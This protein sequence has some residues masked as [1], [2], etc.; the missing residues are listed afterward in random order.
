MQLSL[1][2]FKDLLADGI[3]YTYPLDILD[4][5]LKLLSKKENYQLLAL[6]QEIIEA[7]QQ[8]DLI[9]SERAHAEGDEWKTNLSDPPKSYKSIP[10]PWPQD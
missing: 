8:M 10:A 2:T 9:I 1:N 4:R 5:R 7:L 6:E 3:G